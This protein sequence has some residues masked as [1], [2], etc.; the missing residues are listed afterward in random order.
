MLELHLAELGWPAL[1]AL[2]ETF[3][4]KSVGTVPSTG[5]TEVGR[6]DRNTFGGGIMLYAKDTV[7]HNVTHL[8]D[9]TFERQWFILHTNHGPFTLCVW[10]RPPAYAETLSIEAFN[11]EMALYRPQVSQH[12]KSMWED[13]TRKTQPVLTNTNTHAQTITP[14]LWPWLVVLVLATD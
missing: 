4:D 6:K 8:A 7:A 13:K 14:Q 2:T 5:Y 10:Y 12:P 11:T 1:V 3:L 9:S